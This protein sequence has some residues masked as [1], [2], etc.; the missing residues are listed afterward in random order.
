M[1]KGAVKKKKS[2]MLGDHKKDQLAAKKSKLFN[3]IHVSTNC[4]KIKFVN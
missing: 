2:F 3:K 1:N 4:K